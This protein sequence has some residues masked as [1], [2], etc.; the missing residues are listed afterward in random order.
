MQ[1]VSKRRG[2]QNVKTECGTASW[3]LRPPL[4]DKAFRACTT[5]L[6]ACGMSSKNEGLSHLISSRGGGEAGTIEHFVQYINSRFGHAWHISTLEL[7]PTE[8]MNMMSLARRRYRSPS[9]NVQRA[10]SKVHQPAATSNH[11]K[12]AL[13]RSVGVMWCVCAELPT[14]LIQMHACGEQACNSSC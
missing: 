2:K 13:R 14:S 5:R 9:K 7:G 12:P 10:T 11:L 8:S 3:H 1:S 6:R 4:K